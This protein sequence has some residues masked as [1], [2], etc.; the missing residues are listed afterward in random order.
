LLWSENLTIGSALYDIFSPSKIRKFHKSFSELCSTSYKN[1]YFFKLSQEEE[2]DE[3]PFFNHIGLSLVKTFSMFVGELGEG[4]EILN[5]FVW[6]YNIISG[7]VP[8]FLWIRI[9]ILL[10]YSVPSRC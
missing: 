8:D 6:E 1:L 7:S 10:F 3:Y 5:F 2:K 9:R 4:M